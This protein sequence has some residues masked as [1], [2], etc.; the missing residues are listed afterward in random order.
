MRPAADPNDLEHLLIE[1]VAYYRA[2]APEY[3]QHALP[4]AGGNELSAALDAFEPSGTVL[5]LAC[6]TGVWSSK[7]AWLEPDG[8]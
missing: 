6:G 1:Q 8:G 4:F 7:S 3:E 2:I 5:E